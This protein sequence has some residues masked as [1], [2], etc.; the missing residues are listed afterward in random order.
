[1][2]DEEIVN[3]ALVNLLITM[4]LCSGIACMRGREGLQ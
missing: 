2:E 3:T 4:T 1:M